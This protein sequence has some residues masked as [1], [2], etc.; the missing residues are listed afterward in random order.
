MHMTRNGKIARLSKDVR[1]E[2]NER[3][4]DGEE[5]KKLVKWLNS[6]PEVQED[7]RDGFDGKEITEQNLSQ[8][9][10]GGY[11]D[12]QAQNE[13]LCIMHD[14]REE[15]AE[16]TFKIDP[17]ETQ[18][19]LSQMLTLELAR[20]VRD[21]LEQTTDPKERIQALSRIIGRF[22]QL[23]REECHALRTEVAVKMQKLELADKRRRQAEE[24]WLGRSHSPAEHYSERTAEPADSEQPTPKARGRRK[25]KSQGKTGRNNGQSHRI[26]VDRSEKVKKSTVQSP[27]EAN[28][29]TVQSPQSTVG[30]GE[31]GGKGGGKAESVQSPK[32]DVQSQRGGTS[33]SPDTTVVNQSEPG[34]NQTGLH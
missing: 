8:W 34:N 1:E 9:K 17:E 20:A 12:W 21:L 30:Y 25:E 4:D 19:H 2:L 5:G 7:I 16:Q 26:K 23:R 29:S 6:L 18:R 22:T 31:A 11:R 15:A 3:L 27:Q 24:S 32:P 10:N 13:R 33:S 28:G 14:L